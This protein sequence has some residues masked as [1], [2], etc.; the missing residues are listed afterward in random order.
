MDGGGT[1]TIMEH[2]MIWFATAQKEAQEKA[3]YVKSLF[4]ERVS[5]S[6]LA[7]SICLS[8]L[9]C[10]LFSLLSNINSLL[11]H[12]MVATPSTF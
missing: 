8:K 3:S 6:A 1:K 12:F 4:E 9:L 10:A 5:E 7:L 11:L 2:G